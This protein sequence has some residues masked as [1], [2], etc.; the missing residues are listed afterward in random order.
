MSVQNFRATR[1]PVA[2]RARPTPPLIISNEE[3]AYYLARGRRERSEMIAG[4]IARG[5]RALRRFFGGQLQHF[6]GY[7]VPDK[8]R[9]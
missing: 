5:W 8:V 9:P 4:G 6:R 3:I 2:A 1:P 7:R